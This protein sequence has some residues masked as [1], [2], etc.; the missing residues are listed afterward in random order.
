MAVKKQQQEL[1]ALL[2]EE[3]EIIIESLSEIIRSQGFI[4]ITHK[5]PGQTIN[6]MKGGAEPAHRG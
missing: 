4:V 2:I 5:D 6:L 3:N 1:R